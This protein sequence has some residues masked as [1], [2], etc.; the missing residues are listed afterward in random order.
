MHRKPF[1]QLPFSELPAVPRRPHAFDETRVETLS[2]DSQ[3]LGR[4]RVSVRRMGR[5]GPPPL[6]LVHGMM[7]SNYSWRYVMKPLAEHF[8]VI[9]PDLPGAGY[10]TAPTAPLTAGALATFIGEVQAA[11][12][13]EGCAAIGNSLGGY[14]CLRRLFDDPGAFSRLVLIHPPFFPTVPL[15]ALN[16]IFK[17]PGARRLLR[18]LVHRDP[19][20]WAFKWVHYH[21]ETLKSLEEA[22]TYGEPLS[23]N[24][25]VASFA[26]YLADTLRPR[27]LVAFARDLKARPPAAP[28]LLLYSR[29]DPIVPPSF[30]PRLHA[31]VPSA[32]FEWLDDTSHFAHVDTPELVLSHVVPFL[33]DVL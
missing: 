23:T 11:M 26:S 29:M 14:L 7:T 20:R 9:A 27:E 10:T 13:I 24:E 8:D 31:L 5:A 18:F 15:R 4:L 25:G 16:T 28:M 1:Q 3:P 2:L 6:L 22:R 21:D 17:V 12:G 32:R 33:R 19:V 30:G